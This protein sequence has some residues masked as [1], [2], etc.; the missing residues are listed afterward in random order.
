MKAKHNDLIKGFLSSALTN[1][2]TCS[3]TKRLLAATEDFGVKFVSFFEF[4]RIGAYLV[5][6]NSYGVVPEAFADYYLKQAIYKTDPFLKRAATQGLPF[7]WHQLIQEEDNSAAKAFVQACQGFGMVDGFV[8]PSHA[9]AGHMG[10]VCFMGPLDFDIVTQAQLSQIALYYSAA[11]RRISARPV[12]P[13]PNSLLTPRQLDC[14][15]WIAAGK[16]D[17]EVGSILG[18]S[19]STVNRHVELAKER[20]G[21]RTR[22]QVVVEALQSG[23]LLLESNQPLL[24]TG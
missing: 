10:M 17:W 1:K 8:V 19:E 14:I 18:L 15:R 9:P 13:N 11:I 7:T 12:A 24:L 23:Q 20:L 22:V 3:V 5:P 4:K 16:S 2:T 21:V 6:I